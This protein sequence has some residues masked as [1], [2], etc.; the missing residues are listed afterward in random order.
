MLSGV[1]SYSVGAIVGEVCVG[2]VVLVCAPLP[3]I[4]FFFAKNKY[5]QRVVSHK[6]ARYQK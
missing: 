4:C 3:S 6:I 2:V 5:P 1:L